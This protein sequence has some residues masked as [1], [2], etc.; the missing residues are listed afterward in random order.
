MFLGSRALDDGLLTRHQLR[1]GAWLRLRNDVYADS[2]LERDHGL[3]CRAAALRL[4]AEAVIAGTSA[5]YLYGVHHAAR[6]EDDIDVIVP[7]KAR[8]PRLRGLRVHT[9]NLDPADVVALAGLQLTAPCR[10]C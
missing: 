2:R 1:S 7:W 3:S 6:F 10:T 8:I 9:L 5:A 4:P